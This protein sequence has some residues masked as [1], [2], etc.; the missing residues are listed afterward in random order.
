MATVRLIGIRKEFGDVVA[1]DQFSVDIAD[2][3]FVSFLGP[4]GCG[5]TT[6]LRMIAGFDMPTSGDIYIGD[7][8]MSSVEGNTF[9][10]PEERNIGMVFQNYAVWPHMTVFDNIAYPLKIKK[11]KRGIIKN[12]VEQHLLLVGLEG[13]GERYPHQLSGGQQQRVALARALVMD[14]EVM[15][16]D[17]PLSNLDAKLREE[18]RFEIKDLQKK[19]GV[20]IVYV[21]HD[22]AEAIVM[23]DRIV[24]MDTGYIQQVDSPKGIYENP[25]NKFVADFIGLTNFV[26]CEIISRDTVLLKDGTR[27]HKVKV[28]I[29][30]GIGKKAILSV[31]PENIEIGEKDGDIKGVVTRTVYLG[32]MIDYR[33]TVGDVELR[34]ERDA[35]EVFPEGSKVTLRFKKTFIFSV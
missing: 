7:T 33:I 3:E 21:T 31:R 1:V 8:L 32:N 19:T 6:T 9:A 2:G 35:E 23:S 18:M 17:E 15:L 5:K 12:K 34:V 4:S 25:T 14:P 29:P 26:E 24:V 20:T 22:Q 30:P 27:S 11:E 28:H 16:L 10:S 13:F